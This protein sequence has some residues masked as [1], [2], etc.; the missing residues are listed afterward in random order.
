[1]NSHGNK[2]HFQAEKWGNKDTA[3]AQYFIGSL[4]N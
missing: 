1:M 2:E 4:K 3:F